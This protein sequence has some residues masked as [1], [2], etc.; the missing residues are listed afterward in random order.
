MFSHS[1]IDFRQKNSSIK[2]YVD[3]AYNFEEVYVF[4]NSDFVS[5]VLSEVWRTLL[6]EAGEIC[7]RFLFLHKFSDCP[8]ENG[9]LVQFTI[10]IS[11][12][13]SSSWRNIEMFIEKQK[14]LVKEKE[15][16][17]ERERE[18]IVDVIH[19]RKGKN[20]W[21]FAF[22]RFFIHRKKFI[23]SKLEL[24]PTLLKAWET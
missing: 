5:C 12:S 22:L 19:K 16:E 14:E 1:I 3:D 18:C 11:S 6:L 21:K 7:M 13:P 23:T 10:F 17:R 4:F 2:D 8:D 20:Y 9:K 24:V 15:R